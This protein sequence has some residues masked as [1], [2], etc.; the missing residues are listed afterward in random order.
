M[1]IKTYIKISKSSTHNVVST[2]TNIAKIW[3]SLYFIGCVRLIVVK[4]TSTIFFSCKGLFCVK[5]CNLPY[6]RKR[7]VAI[8]CIPHTSAFVSAEKKKK[9]VQH[10]SIAF[11]RRALACFWPHNSCS[12]NISNMKDRGWP[13][14]QTPREELKIRRAAEYFWRTSRCLE[15]WSNS[16]VLRICYIFSIETKTKEKTEK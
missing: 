6:S 8:L 4:C 15:M 10:N 16:D 2:G 13:H 12:C 3:L 14:F 11:N 9:T 5:R 1:L 7:Q